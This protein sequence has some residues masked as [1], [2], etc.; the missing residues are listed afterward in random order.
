MLASMRS[1]FTR[2][3]RRPSLDRGVWLLVCG[4]L[5]A[6]NAT[7]CG[8]IAAGRSL[9]QGPPDCPA[10]AQASAGGSSVACVDAETARRKKEREALES[11]R[12]GAS[13]ARGFSIASIVVGSTVLVGGLLL[14]AAVANSTSCG[15]GS[16]FD[17]DDFDLRTSGSSTCD[18]TAAGVSAGVTTGVIGV[19]LI[20]LGIVGVVKSDAR[21]KEIDKQLKVT[22]KTGPGA[23]GLALTGSF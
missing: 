16:D 9:F 18:N 6:L 14:S 13:V 17:D 1:F 10:G 19:T 23:A 2:G 4:A 21:I 8:A 11:R 7:G 5:L 15:D 22:L 20:T 12:R 3:A